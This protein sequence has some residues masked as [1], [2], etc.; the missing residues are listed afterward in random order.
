MQLLTLE[1][2]H[3]QTFAGMENRSSSPPTPFVLLLHEIEATP[4]E[5][6]ADLLKAIRQFRRNIP[7]SGLPVIDAEQA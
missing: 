7:S 6:W 3:L 5:Y 4:K 2:V 1:S